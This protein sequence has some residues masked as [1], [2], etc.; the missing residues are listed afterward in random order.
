MRAWLH[1]LAVL[2]AL[3]LSACADHTSSSDQAEPLPPQPYGEEEA[4]VE[5]WL[6]TMELS[7]RELYVARDAVIS[8]LDL[9]KGE[10]VADLG[11]GTGLYTLLFSPILGETGVVY[12]VDIEPRFLRL[13]NQRVADLELENV[14]AVLSREDDITLPHQSVDVVF[15]A[16]TYHYFADPEKVMASVRKS[17]KAD[18]RLVILDYNYDPSKANDP[19]RDHLRF[20]RDGLVDEITSFGFSTKKSPVVDGLNDFYMLEFVKA[21][22]DKSEETP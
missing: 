15:I 6:E 2:A 1:G 18:G 4:N 9:K 17:L 22:D 10:K 8:A 5:L 11:A 21:D 13:V 12:A 14:V 19:S 20:G 7:N 3:T 16:D